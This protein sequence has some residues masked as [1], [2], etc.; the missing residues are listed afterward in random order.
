MGMCLLLMLGHM[1]VGLLYLFNILENFHGYQQNPPMR[2]YN[3]HPF[4]RKQKKPTHTQSMYNNFSNNNS[5]YN[6]QMMN[7]MNSLNRYELNQFQAQIS[8]PNVFYRPEQGFDHQNQ[9]QSMNQYV[10]D[11]EIDPQY[12]DQEMNQED[13]TNNYYE[14]ENMG[15]EQGQRYIQEQD[16]HEQ[17]MHENTWPY[18]NE[19]EY[20]E[21][22]LGYM[23]GGL[24]GVHQSEINLHQIRNQDNS[25]MMNSQIRMKQ[26]RP[27]SM[28]N[29]NHF[30]KYHENQQIQSPYHHQQ[31][32][33]HT[34]S[35]KSLNITPMSY[36]N[37][38][39]NP[40]MMDGSGD[41]LSVRSLQQN[42]YLNR[43]EDDCLYMNLEE[44]YLHK[45]SK[46][47]ENKNGISI[48]K[49]HYDF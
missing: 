25:N 17:Y 38:E 10:Y 7:T 13:Y 23:R 41:A 39:M 6:N 20:Q 3:Q 2:K 49:S 28:Q 15:Q 8:E 36:Y 26:N 40:H 16:P 11:D 5:G 1:L 22:Q 21:Q 37:N 18:R 12:Q 27:Q 47:S 14:P 35:K 43:Y 31:E 30:E 45:V 33:K 48:S 4:R 44:E 32:M 42:M 34:Y 9:A 19:P 46:K 29:F 24:G